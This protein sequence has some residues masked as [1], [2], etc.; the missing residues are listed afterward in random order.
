MTEIFLLTAV[1]ENNILIFNHS[2]NICKDLFCAR[3][4]LSMVDTV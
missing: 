2:T 3:Y 4:G 1:L